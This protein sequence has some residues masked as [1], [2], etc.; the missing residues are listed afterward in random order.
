M[1]ENLQRFEKILEVIDASISK[2]EFL[3]AFESV[4]AYVKDFDTKTTKSLATFLETLTT[5]VD[6]KLATVV[7]GKDGKDG[8]DGQSIVGPQ[9][10]QGAPGETIVG[11]AGR[12]GRDGSPDMAEDIRNKLELLEGEERLDAKYIK[13]LPETKH[14]H[15]GGGIAHP[16]LW[17][18]ADVDVAGI[19]PGQAIKWDGIRW[20]PFTPVGGNTPVFGEIPTDSGDHLSFTLAHTPVAGTVRLYRGGAYQLAGVSEDYTIS[21][22]TITLSIALATGEKLACDYEY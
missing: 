19:V 14:V 13:N 18:L 4:I 7:N 9:G 6:D 20:I 16:P 5:K 1:K 12:D 21:G 22:A 8:R 10:E 17:S 2:D 11:P 3:K 15:V